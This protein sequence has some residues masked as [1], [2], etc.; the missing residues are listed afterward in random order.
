MRQHKCSNVASIQNTSI[1]D[2]FHRVT[3]PEWRVS[4]LVVKRENDSDMGKQYVLYQ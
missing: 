4:Y 1:K 2:K 3:N